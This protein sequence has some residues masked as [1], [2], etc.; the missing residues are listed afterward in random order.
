[1]RGPEHPDTLASRNNLAICH[2]DLGHHE[3]AARLYKETLGIKE[4]V[5]G[6]EHPDT[7]ASRNNLAAGYHH[8]GR[9]EE[10]VLLGRVTLMIYARVLG[11]EHPDTLQSRY[12]LALSY[13]ALDR[14]STRLNSSHVVISYAVFC[15]KKK[16]NNTRSSHNTYRP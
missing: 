9:Y 8:L 3:E 16:T 1:M 12:N 10:A 7:L 2:G 4:R 6:P 5:L 11:P 13:R 14:K 15:L